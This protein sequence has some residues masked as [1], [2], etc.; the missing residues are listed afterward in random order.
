MSSEIRDNLY[1]RGVIEPVRREHIT[2]HIRK[3]SLSYL[4]FLKRKRSGKV[5]GHGCA[6]GRKQR[7]CI[8]RGESSSPTISIPALTATCLLNAI[9]GRFVAT[10]DIPGDFLQAN[11]DD[12][13]W[14]KFENEMV[15][16]LVDID[17]ERYGPCVCEYKGQKFLY[18]RAI[19]AIYRCLKSALLFYKLF[20]GELRQWG[21]KPSAYDAC[22]MNKM[23]NNKQKKLFD[24]W[25]IVRS[26]TRMRQWFR[27]CSQN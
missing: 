9:E 8:T 11:L 18:A 5:N 26:V 25:V 10:I 1:G 13:V 24:T 27:I 22:T 12:E 7:E 23:V 21:F 15:D 16:V 19:K 17:P 14:I 6:D 20:T 4:M 3:E 2:H